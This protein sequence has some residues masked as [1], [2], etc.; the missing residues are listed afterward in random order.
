MCLG[1][2]HVLNSPSCAAPPLAFYQCPNVGDKVDTVYED[3][4][5]STAK[6]VRGK[7]ILWEGPRTNNFLSCS[8]P[9]QTTVGR[10]V[11]VVDDFGRQAL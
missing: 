3:R 4:S 8:T 6:Y 10:S 1:L 11:V 7:K 5:A 2:S 9:T